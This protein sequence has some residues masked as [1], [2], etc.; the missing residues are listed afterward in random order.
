MRYHVIL[1]DDAMLDIV[2]VYDYIKQQLFAPLA[3]E[4]FL[5]GLYSRIADLERTAAIYA[6]STYRDV[7]RYD[8]RAHHILYNGFVIIYTIHKPYAVIHRIIHGSQIKE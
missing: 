7:L 2:E 4:N 6:V 1:K 3:A 5:R 8:A